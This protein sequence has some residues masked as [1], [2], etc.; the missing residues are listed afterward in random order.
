M[1][2]NSKNQNFGYLLTLH[3]FMADY[4]LHWLN[5]PQF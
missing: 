1:T 3:S 4:Y 2:M 5:Y